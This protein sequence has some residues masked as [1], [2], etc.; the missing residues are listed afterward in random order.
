MGSENPVDTL[1]GKINNKLIFIHK[2]IQFWEK[3]NKNKAFAYLF[4]VDNVLICR[5]LLCV[6]EI[7]PNCVESFLKILVI[8]MIYG[9]FVNR[10]FI[11]SDRRRNSVSTGSLSLALRWSSSDVAT[12]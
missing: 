9:L 3:A 2:V 7:W 4:F 12:P 6:F 1:S 8:A 11:S 5:M 10:F